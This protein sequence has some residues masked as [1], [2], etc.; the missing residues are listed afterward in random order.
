MHEDAEYRVGA[1]GSCTPVIIELWLRPVHEAALGYTSGQYVLL[2]DLD[3]RVPPRSYSIANAPREDGSLSVL[4]TSVT[5]GETSQWA[6][7][8][9]VGDVVA[10]SGPFGTFVPETDRGVPQLYLAAG[11][12]LAPVRALA[13]AARDEGRLD[14]TVLV[15]SARTEEHLID[16]EVF[17]AWKREYPGFGY[18]RT[19]TRAGG[20][21]PVGR[22]PGQLA[23]LVP[24]LGG[25]EVFAAGP[26]GFVRECAVVARAAG[27]PA[28]RLH[29]EE[30]Y[31]E[32]HPWISSPGNLP[33]DP[34][35]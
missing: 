28:G 26:P 20:P 1:T 23:D 21:P 2:N 35:G 25:R 30:F 15:M 18:L 9:Q 29:T 7:R 19:L 14:R 17:R 6:H 4:V 11:S 8:L 31:F 34:A 24:D 10:L 27:V 22:L 16:A 32:P 5:G 12:G 13:E 33:A 3:Y